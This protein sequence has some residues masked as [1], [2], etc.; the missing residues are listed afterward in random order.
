MKAD[1]LAELTRQADERKL[2]LRIDK[3]AE[4][5][6]GDSDVLANFKRHAQGIGLNPMQVWFIYLAKH[7]DAVA[8][9]CNTGRES[10]NEPIEGRVD[11]IE[12]YMMLFRGLVYENKESRKKDEI[13]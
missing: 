4:Y 6:R 9:Y 11:D 2:K 3:G 5:T 10:S 13:F 7:I 12:V 1:K 8:S